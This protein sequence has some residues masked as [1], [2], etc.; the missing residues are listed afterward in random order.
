V[1]E[2][3]QD[4]LNNIDPSPA[5]CLADMDRCDTGVAFGLFADATVAVVS[6]VVNAA[7]PNIGRYSETRVDEKLYV[8][9]WFDW[10][11]NGEWTEDEREIHWWGGPGMTGAADKGNC[12]AGCDMWDVTQ[13]DKKVI[14]T[15]DVP[16][17]LENG[18]LWY[19]VR[20]D[21]GQDITDP[22][23]PAT[24]GE[25]EDYVYVEG[26]P[27]ASEWGMVGLTLLLLTGITIKFSRRM[28]AKP[29]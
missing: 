21:Y 3:D 5:V 22:H 9:A 19:R 15:L 18:Y 24:Y 17:P 20:L 16:S 12:T 2:R 28:V 4:A 23:G 13:H 26:T 25:V 6:F 7:T 14:F 1:P 27:A 8:H 10:D 29:A 11:Q